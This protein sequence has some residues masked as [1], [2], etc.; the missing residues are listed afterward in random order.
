MV[1]CIRVPRHDGNSARLMLKEKGA[2]DVGH[3][4]LNDGDFLFIPITCGNLDG[5]EIFD[6]DLEPIERR[7]SDYRAFL[8]EEIRDRLP[9]SYDNIGDVTVV[10]I[11]D[12]LLPYKNDIGEALMKASSNTRCVLMDNGV[13]GELRIRDVEIIA[14]EGPTET[15]HRESGVVIKTDP[16][17]VY[18]N[19]RLA[20]E[21]ERIASL[22]KD[23]ETII[24][25]FAGVAP[26]PLT[27]C[28]AANP[29]VVYSIDMNRDAVEY[30]KINAE[31]NRFDNII[32]IEGDAREVIKGLPDADR[33]IM[34]L[35]QSAEDFLP[36][37]LSKTKKNGIVHMHKILGR[38]EIGQF[39]KDL[40]GNMSSH[41][42][43]CEIENIKELKTYSPS[44]SVYVIDV[45]KL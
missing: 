20:T 33:V 9:N 6:R 12:D 19:Q 31:L 40:I 26:F 23:G 32:P 24:D 45:K 43:K 8:P 25:M 1:T 41:G 3:K 36:D 2:L 39:C 37:A 27:I 15:L 10:K 34:N 7:E 11:P 35:P 30:A 21:R 42:F 29:K 22:V 38:D 13:K 44:A 18:Y 5:Y 16:A 14:G 28:R 17:K 4:I